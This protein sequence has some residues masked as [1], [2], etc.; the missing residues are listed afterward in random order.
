M[1]RK[2]YG[3]YQLEKERYHVKIEAINKHRFLILGGIP[4][5][6][7]Y[8]GPAYGDEEL[9]MMIFPIYVTVLV[10]ITSFPKAEKE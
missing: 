7:E 3:M 6:N 9:N 10:L 2:S 5:R 8:S 4:P 1:S